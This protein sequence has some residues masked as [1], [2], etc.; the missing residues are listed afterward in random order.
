MFLV[1]LVRFVLAMPAGNTVG[2]HAEGTNLQPDEADWEKLRTF[3]FFF[4]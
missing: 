2:T 4:R 3:L 1:F